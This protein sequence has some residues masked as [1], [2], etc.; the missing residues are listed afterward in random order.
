MMGYYAVIVHKFNR[1]LVSSWKIIP[2]ID[3]PA[4]RRIEHLEPGMVG[5][6][7]FQL[8]TA[9]WHAFDGVCWAELND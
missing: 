3:Q 9:C 6:S 7:S 4:L 2:I 8:W 5:R 1:E